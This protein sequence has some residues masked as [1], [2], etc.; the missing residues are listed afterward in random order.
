M[1]NDN[2]THGGFVQLNRADRGLAVRFE[3]PQQSEAEQHQLSYAV[4]DQCMHALFI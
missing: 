4:S 1:R 3:N 2:K